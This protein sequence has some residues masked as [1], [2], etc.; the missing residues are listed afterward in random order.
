MSMQDEIYGLYNMTSAMDD[1]EIITAVLGNVNGEG[2]TSRDGILFLTTHFI[3]ISAIAGWFTSDT[4]YIAP[5]SHI[6]NVDIAA[7]PDDPRIMV[8]LMSGD[9]SLRINLIKDL[10]HDIDDV[11]YIIERASNNSLRFGLEE[12]HRK[13]WE[14]LES[15]DFDDALHYA[16]LII[17]SHPTSIPGYTLL[18][19]AYELKDELPACI[20]ALEYCIQLGANN[21]SDLYAELARI[22]AF[23][24]DYESAI[25]YANNALSSGMDATALVARSWAKFRTGDM[26]GANEDIRRATQIE[27][28][29]DQ[30]WLVLANIAEKRRDTQDLALAI[31]EFTRL[32]EVAHANIFQISLF[33]LTKE[34]EAALNFAQDIFDEHK[35]DIW[36]VEEFLHAASEANVDA[37][38]EAL[39]ELDQIHDSDQLYQILSSALLLQANVPQDA[40]SRI[41]RFMEA[42]VEEDRENLDITFYVFV[43]LIH[44]AAAQEDEEFDKSWQLI[45]PFLDEKDWVTDEESQTYYGSLCFYA[46]VAKLNLGDPQSALDWLH[47]AEAIGSFILTSIEEL[48]PTLLDQAHQTVQ[49]QDL[50]LGG[51]YSQPITDKI[52]AYEVLNK[53]IEALES[54]GRL[55]QIERQAHHLRAQFDQPPLI[56]VM[57]EYSVGKSTF[58]NAL[59][60]ADLLPTG[61]GVTTGTIVWLRYGDQEH[62]RVVF[63][64]GHILEQEGLT[65]ISSLVVESQTGRTARDIRHVEVFL[66]AK[67]LRQINLVDTPGLNAPFPEHKETTEQFLEEADAIL[68][69]FNVEAAGKASEGEFLSKV[70]AYQR[71]AVAVV[72]QIDL[73]PPFEVEDVL[74]YIRED[75]GE[76]FL[77]VLGVSGKLALDAVLEDAPTKRERSRIPALERWLDKNLLE[78]S[79]AIKAEATEL[80]LKELIFDV[81]QMRRD[82]DEQMAKHAEL[83]EEQA[84]EL[85]SWI[86][87]ILADE[88]DAVAERL[89]RDI[90]DQIDELS[91][92]IARSSTA[93]YFD[94]AAIET[95][96]YNFRTS[97]E[98]L[99]SA[100]GVSLTALYDERVAE[101]TL[102]LD[103]LNSELNSP[104]LHDELLKLNVH[105]PSWRKDLLDYLE[106]VAAYSLGF[107]NASGALYSLF[108]IPEG[109]RDNP[110]VIADL[111]RT[112]LNFTSTRAVDSARRWNRE[113][114]A[115]FEEELAKLQRYLHSDASQVRREVY[116]PVESL[117]QLYSAPQTT[118]SARHSRARHGE[119]EPV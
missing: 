92:N 116:R 15:H 86:H 8:T 76:T 54:S 119:G 14:A 35:D 102:S 48:L 63:R 104:A 44:A 22:S 30:A 39:S 103:S 42:L 49:G 7:H 1:E 11:K 115:N 73:V 70:S 50:G 99:W 27:P 82:F 28:D 96:L 114:I 57:G 41:H 24:D 26:N 113:L 10:T 53:L 58:I 88:L 21:A 79:R 65:N 4:Y 100:F 117:L 37:G 40:S 106:Q 89:T 101:L 109:R 51:S 56:A 81:R 83:I 19:S 20:E 108:D 29:N 95:H 43:A 118:S 97:C 16:S 80:K 23:S 61:E 6:Y 38:L 77:E 12:I 67:I 18:A 31:Q 107:F 5:H 3:G 46:G 60:G 110:R 33:N 69:L 52:S 17:D 78:Q 98:A 45:E 87:H 75:F 93:E 64:D 68:F 85:T 71:K 2:H 55:P 62:L 94:T 66:N 72:N 32:G 13:G 36:F 91:A 59:L 105:I 90:D 111:L 34:Y 112:T 25:E 84:S 47:K 9:E 74:D